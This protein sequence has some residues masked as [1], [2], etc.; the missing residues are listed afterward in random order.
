LTYQQNYSQKHLPKRAKRTKRGSLQAQGIIRTHL[1]IL[2]MASID[3]ADWLV[4][5]YKK[6]EEN[7][8]KAN[9]EII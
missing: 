9:K 5:I 6:N 3:Q 4:L 7:D 2:S 1:V 8:T